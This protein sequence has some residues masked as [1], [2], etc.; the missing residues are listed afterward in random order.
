MKKFDAWIVMPPKNQEYPYAFFV[1]AYHG[2]YPVFLT[3]KEAQTWKVGK[4]EFGGKVLKCEI[5]VVD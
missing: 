2:Q 3:R 5:T 1:R 4:N